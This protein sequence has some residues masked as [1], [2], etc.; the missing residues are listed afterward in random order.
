MHNSQYVTPDLNSSFPKTFDQTLSKINDI[1][2]E[3]NYK[4]IQI[5]VDSPQIRNVICITTIRASRDYI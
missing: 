1:V 2:T 5:C 3:M 4:I